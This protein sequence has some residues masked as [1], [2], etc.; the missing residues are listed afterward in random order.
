MTFLHFASISLVALSAA[1]F[2]AAGDDSGLISC[3]GA[4][5][6]PSEYT[7][8]DGST[9]CPVLF[10]QPTLPCGG[11]CYSPDMYACKDGSHLTLLSEQS[12][13]FALVAQSSNPEL[14]GQTVH[15]CNH[16][17]GIGDD[18]RTCVY[19][20]NA[21]PL[22]VCNEYENNTV[23]RP[24]GRMVCNGLSLSPSFPPAAQENTQRSR[25]AA[26]RWIHH[27]LYPLSHC[28]P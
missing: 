5:Y 13:P 27:L 17:F 28:R 19:C 16:M 6:Y 12:G 14:N 3:G 15:A 20:Y 24:D 26:T 4:G 11:A 1:P 18:A 9:L 25:S 2:L 10:G 8:Y 23:L 21:P 7:C 22:Y